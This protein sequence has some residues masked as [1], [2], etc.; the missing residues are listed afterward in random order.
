MPE[1]PGVA[2]LVAD[3]PF[4]ALFDPIGRFYT[5]SGIALPP[6]EQLEGAALPEPARSL[7]VH[8][9]DMTSTLR[10]YHR[11]P[12]GLRVCSKSVGDGML[13]RLVIL[14]RADTGEPVEFGAIQIFLDAFDAGVREAILAGE[15]PL[16]GIL[17]RMGVPYSS[18]PRAFF[19][20]EADA[21]VGLLLDQVVSRP[22][23]GRCNVLS[24]PDGVPL[25]R[26][27]E[28]LPEMP[29]S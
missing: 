19:R 20:M 25:A 22:L 7:L 15:E 17:G 29:V 23:Y 11:A 6:V 2:E 26:I 13:S 14:D 28:I 9:R 10:N 5:K 18:A 27:V 1:H 8:Q 3:D 21:F 4:V 24:R 12:I 16:G